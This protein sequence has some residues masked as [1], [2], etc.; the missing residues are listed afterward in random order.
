LSAVTPIADIDRHPALQVT[1]WLQSP[2][3]LVFCSSSPKYFGVRL[4]QNTWCFEKYVRTRIPV[5]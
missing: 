2:A 4:W 5:L 3:S 1:S